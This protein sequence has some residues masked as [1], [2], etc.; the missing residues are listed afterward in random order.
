MQCCNDV[1]V[2]RWQNVCKDCHFF[3]EREREKCEGHLESITCRETYKQRT[4]EAEHNAEVWEK[5][6]LQMTSKP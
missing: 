6:F 2:Q 1:T 3:R 4:N 5:W